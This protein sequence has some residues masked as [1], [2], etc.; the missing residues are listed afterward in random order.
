LTAFVLDA[1]AFLAIIRGEPGADIA[2]ARLPGCIMSAVNMSEAMMR[3][4]E[5]GSPLDLMRE[6][7]AAQQVSVVPFD[8]ELAIAAALLRPATRHLGLSFA[9]RAC[10]A[11]AV[12]H[13]ATVVTADRAWAT[14]DL[15]CPV[16]LIR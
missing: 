2:S 15:P 5:K 8:D 3:G 12:G 16:E 4:L 13:N 11:T 1:S 6:L 7:L 10:I 14:L 9:D